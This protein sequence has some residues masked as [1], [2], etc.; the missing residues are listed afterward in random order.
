MTDRASLWR[1]AV[2]AAAQVLHAQLPAVHVVDRQQ[3]A[4]AI[5][6]AVLDRLGTPVTARDKL[7]AHV[8]TFDAL[9]VRSATVRAVDMVERIDHNVTIGVHSHAEVVA[10]A[11][12]LDLPRPTHRIANG[13]RYVETAVHPETGTSIV[14]QGAV[15]STRD[16]A[17]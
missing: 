14:I 16:T 15:R 4:L 6:T 2:E 10:L 17:A 3:M 9:A 7:D 5:G 11:A 8:A 1:H 12:E 13:Y